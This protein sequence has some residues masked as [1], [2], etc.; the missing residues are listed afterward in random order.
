MKTL[1]LNTSNIN[2]LKEFIRLFAKYQISL[3]STCLD[4]PEIQADPTTVVI[5]KAS[6]VG[7]EILVED[8]SLEIAQASIGI[9]IRWQLNDLPKYI[10]Q[11]AIW[12]VLLAYRQKDRVYVYEGKISGQIV[13]PKGD[14]SFGFDSFFLPEG[15]EYTFG[16]SK[17]NSLNARAKAVEAFVLKMPISIHPPIFDWHGSW[18]L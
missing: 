6:Q 11:K 1:T 5:H 2:K 18:Q 14:L 8:T 17:P 12:R 16:E 4:I 9:N 15:S 10:G 3:H 13:A 7:E